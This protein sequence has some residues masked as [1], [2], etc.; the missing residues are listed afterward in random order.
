MRH[1]SKFAAWI[2]SGGNSVF[3]LP[4]G[5][6]VRAPE[7]KFSVVPNRLLD[8]IIDDALVAG[9]ARLNGFLPEGVSIDIASVDL[10][11]MRD[12]LRAAVAD[13]LGETGV[14]V[15]PNDPVIK[16]ILARYAESLS[17]LTDN[18]TDAITERINRDTDSYE[19]RRQHMAAIRDGGQFD[20]ICRFSVARPRFEDA[21]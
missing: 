16:A 17:G 7:V 9:V 1:E 20:G 8:S 4:L 2:R 6:T 12:E 19:A 21:Q 5:P 10:T 18:A 15:N 11:A 13:R 3:V 14:P